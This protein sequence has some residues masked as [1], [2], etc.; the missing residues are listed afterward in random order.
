MPSNASCPYSPPT[1]EKGRSMLKSIIATTV[2]VGLLALAGGWYV[3]DQHREI[4]RLQHQL[5]LVSSASNEQR[6]ILAQLQDQLFPEAGPEET[7]QRLMTGTALPGVRL[8]TQH[9]LAACFALYEGA[10]REGD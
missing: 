5:F 4:A 1:T 3:R 10:Q 9:F 7:R 2:V 6:R 8:A